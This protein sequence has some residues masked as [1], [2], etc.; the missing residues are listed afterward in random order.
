M[1]QYRDEVDEAMKVSLWRRLLESEADA[2]NEYYVKLS[3]MMNTF[4]VCS[5]ISS[6]TI[7]S[8]NIF[9]IRWKLLSTFTVKLM[10]CP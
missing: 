10:H 6:F 7:F 4:I 8:A 3:S 2:M 9:D 1:N 5:Y